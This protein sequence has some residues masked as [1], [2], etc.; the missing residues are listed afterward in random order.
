M[1]TAASTPST[2]FFQT[3][4]PR[5]CVNGNHSLCVS[6]RLVPDA[7]CL[8]IFCVRIPTYQ[9]FCVG[10]LQQY[11]A[12]HG[13]CVR[14]TEPPTTKPK[15]PDRSLACL[16]HRKRPADDTDSLSESNREPQL[17]DE[18]RG[19]V[20]DPSI[21]KEMNK[22][23]R[24]IVLDDCKRAKFPTDDLFCQSDEWGSS[25]EQEFADCADTE[26]LRFRMER[27]EFY[28]QM[29]NLLLWAHYENRFR[30]SSQKDSFY[31]YGMIRRLVDDDIDS[32]HKNGTLF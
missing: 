21:L 1:S 3:P 25:D 32:A 30:P 10:L 16:D 15:S 8:C 18:A 6:G 29:P 19:S 24:H 7:G 23:N 14:V 22:T 20:A 27:H 26:D 9:E 13:L 2:T 28:E 4:E 12:T 17:L 31:P 11:T 5:P